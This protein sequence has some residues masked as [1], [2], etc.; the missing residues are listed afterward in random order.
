MSR[1]HLIIRRLQNLLALL[2]RTG[3]L[4][5]HTQVRLSP[6]NPD[7]VAEW[8]GP[9]LQAGVGYM[10]VFEGEQ[11]GTEGALM[12]LDGLVDLQENRVHLKT[13]ETRQVRPG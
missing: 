11:L 10:R 8:A 4:Y 3:Q 13:R 9:Y 7:S 1:H 5:I 6:S 12:V 2:L